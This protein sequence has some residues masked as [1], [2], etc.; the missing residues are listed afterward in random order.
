MLPARKTRAGLG[1]NAKCCGP[2]TLRKNA[3]DA[4]ALLATGSWAPLLAIGV[5]ALYFAK[6]TNLPVGKRIAIS[7]HGFLLFILALIAAIVHATGNSK[8]ALA[9]PYAVAFVLPAASI[10]CAIVWLRAGLV[11]LLLLTVVAAALW[12]FFVGGMAVTGDWL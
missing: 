4:A 11:H 2:I 12:T 8:A 9:V 3:M 10:L 5:S 1:F 6:G 7:A